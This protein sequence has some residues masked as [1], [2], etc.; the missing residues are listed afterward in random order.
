MVCESRRASGTGGVGTIYREVGHP[1]W[2]IPIRY[3]LEVTKYEPSKE[4]S[5]TTKSGP[6]G[7][8][9]FLLEPVARG[10]RFTIAG[11]LRLPGLLRFAEPLVASLIQKHQARNLKRLK[12]LLEAHI[13]RSGKDVAG[14]SRRGRSVAR[15]VSS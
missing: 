5:F 2:P 1:V 11:T 10:T 3:E 13:P 12:E 7:A 15:G 6:S 4:I 8:G 14:C 9:S